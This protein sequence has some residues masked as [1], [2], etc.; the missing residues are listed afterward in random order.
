MV[1]GR[2]KRAAGGIYKKV[3]DQGN[4]DKV[5][6]RMVHVRTDIRDYDRVGIEGLKK[7]DGV[8][9]VVEDDVLQVVVGPG[10]VN[11]VA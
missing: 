2:I 10:A 11:K 1:E 5:I 6:H 9:G 7:I 4:M 3:G 8:M